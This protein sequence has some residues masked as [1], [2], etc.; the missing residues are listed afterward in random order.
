MK[1][2]HCLGPFHVRCRMIYAGR[3]WR[4]ASDVT[5][6]HV[7]PVNIIV[8]SEKRK[9]ERK[10]KNIPG[11]RALLCC[12]WCWWWKWWPF[13]EVVMVVE[14]KRKEEVYS[15]S[16]WRVMSTEE[17]KR[18]WD[19]R[20]EVTWCFRLW[21]DLENFYLHSSDTSQHGKCFVFHFSLMVF[22]FR[23]Y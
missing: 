10:E 20:I 21:T 4:S 6:I 13:V 19:V 3:W 18:S 23:F 2:F 8:N 16:R 12:S 14:R 1:E 7:V 17:Y 15:Q 9:K 5:V 22:I 11:T